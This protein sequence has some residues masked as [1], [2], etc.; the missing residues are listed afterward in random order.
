MDKWRGL[1]RRAVNRYFV[2]VEQLNYLA[3]RCV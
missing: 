3:H 2:L 1:A